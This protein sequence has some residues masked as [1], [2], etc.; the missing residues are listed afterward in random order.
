[1]LQRK[2]AHFSPRGVIAGWTEALQLMKAGDKFVSNPARLPSVQRRHLSRCPLTTCWCAGRV[3][4]QSIVSARAHRR[5]EAQRGL[6]T[7]AFRLL[8][9]LLCRWELAVPSE[10]GYG[11]KGSGSLIPAVNIPSSPPIERL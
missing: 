7:A 4:D 1:V 10:L 8:D 5:F 9:H 3:G 11:T 2:P 6:L